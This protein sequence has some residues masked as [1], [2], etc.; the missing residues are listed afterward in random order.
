MLIY[1]DPAALCDLDTD[2]VLSPLP[3][4][5][6]LWEAGDKFAW[7]EVNERGSPHQPNFALASNGDLVELDIGK[8]CSG[9]LSLYA[10]FQSRRTASWQ[11]WC[12]GMDS[13]G[14][15]VMLAASLAG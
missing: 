1:F 11:E 13:F 15:L 12:A 3:S 8:P 7:K 4:R 10:E 6:T 9:G 5:K 2:L 14:G